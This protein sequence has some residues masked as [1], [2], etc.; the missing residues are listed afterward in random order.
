MI[1]QRLRQGRSPRQQEL[2]QL[3]CCHSGQRL[4]C[5]RRHSALQSAITMHLC[6]NQEQL[7][8]LPQLIQQLVHVDGGGAIHLR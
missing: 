7:A 2:R 3:R 4:A 6:A 5:R 8:L 1:E